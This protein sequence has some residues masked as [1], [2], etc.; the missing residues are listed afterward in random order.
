M[1]TKDM[2]K[3]EIEETLE[4]KGDFVKIDYLSNYLKQTPPIEMRKF[5]YLKL[6]EIYLQ[7][8]MFSEAA[9]MYKNIS[10]NS[11]TFREKRENYMKESKAY[12]LA[13]NF[14]AS[15]EALKRA[16]A[17]GNSR[18]KEK[19][20]EEVVQFYKKEGSKMETKMKSGAVIKL[21][22]KLIR[23]RIN[24]EEKLRLKEKLL[25]LYDKLGKRKEYNLLKSFKV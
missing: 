8:S 20:Y 25:E 2:R 3:K 18:E 12:I 16:M 17:E 9:K 13:G 7:K 21:Y 10:I 6:A 1:L 5:G 15:D 22:E 4:N 14:E 19:C 11:L 23:M 24:Q